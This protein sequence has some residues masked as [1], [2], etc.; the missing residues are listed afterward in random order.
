GILRIWLG[1]SWLSAGWSKIN[2]PAWTGENAGSAIKGFLNG[3]LA[4][5]G[6]AYPEVHGW[7]ASFVENIALPNSKV[8]SYLVAFGEFFAGLA[9]IIGAFTLF[10]ALGSVFMSLN[11]LYGGT[12][13]SN[14]EMLVVGIFIVIFF[15]SAGY[16]GLDF[17]LMP[18]IQDKYNKLLYFLKDKK[19]LSDSFVKKIECHNKLQS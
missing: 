19:V 9:L 2:S 4:K 6:G 5:A 13:S 10:A 12:S 14:P 1:W 17:Y 8:F 3:T 16:Y 15:L 7:Y 18:F 11:Y